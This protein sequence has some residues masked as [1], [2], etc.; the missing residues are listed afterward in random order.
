MGPGSLTH[1]TICGTQCCV[2]EPWFFHE[3]VGW[4]SKS[5]S[6]PDGFRVIDSG[7]P[8][9]PP[10]VKPSGV[11]AACPLTEGKGQS[12][13]P[14]LLAGEPP[15]SSHSSPLPPTSQASSAEGEGEPEELDKQPASEASCV[16]LGKRQPL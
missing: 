6:R 10:G 5:P 12:L 13:P 2:P 1:I 11:L 9:D 14:P 15:F 3:G 4:V 8:T 16:N 7:A